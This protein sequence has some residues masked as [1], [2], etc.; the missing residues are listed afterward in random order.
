MTQPL[1]YSFNESAAQKHVELFPLETGIVREPS[2]QALADSIARE[3]S[4][5][6]YP[7][8]VLKK[9]WQQGYAAM[10]INEGEIV[11]YTSVVPVFS[12]ATRPQL[13][14]ILGLEAARM[15]PVDLFEFATGWTQPDYRRKG[16]SLQLRQKLLGRFSGPSC[17]HI[18]ISIGL[19]AS[20]ILERLD[21]RLIGWSNLAFVTSLIGV[22]TAGLE[23]KIGV[24]WSPPAEL[25]RYEGEHLSP[26]QDQDHPWAEFCHFWVSNPALAVELNQQL[27]RLAGGNLHRWRE[28]VVT[29]LTAPSEFGWKLILFE[30]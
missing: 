16:I 13:S 25:K 22:P 18:S 30:D 21:W 3:T 9:R 6:A 27:S 26:R 12:T 15:P 19:G 5:T 20:P 1:T 4:L 8:Q 24:G 28:A 2:W 7:P 23:D 14:A 17:L 10:A 11:S 29:V